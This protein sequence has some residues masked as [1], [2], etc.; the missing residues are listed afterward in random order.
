MEE[1]DLFARHFNIFCTLSRQTDEERVVL[2]TKNDKRNLKRVTLREVRNEIKNN[3]MASKR[4][5]NDLITG[6]ILR[7]RCLEK[8]INCLM[9]LFG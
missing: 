2:V 1:A 9:L 3:L 7:K 8:F 6:K 4:L 5:G